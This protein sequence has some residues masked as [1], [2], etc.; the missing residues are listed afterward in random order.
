MGAVDVIPENSQYAY[1]VVVQY[2]NSKANQKVTFA[3]RGQQEQE[4][5]SADGQDNV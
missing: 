1:A 5:K 4:V 2:R 3:A